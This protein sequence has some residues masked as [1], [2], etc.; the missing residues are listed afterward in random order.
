[1]KMQI[2]ATSKK[3]EPDTENIIG[4]IGDD[5]VCGRSNK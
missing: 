5:E 1:M 3:A 2:F 4:F